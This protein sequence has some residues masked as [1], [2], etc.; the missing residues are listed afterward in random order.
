[1]K[2][3]DI[4]RLLALAAIWG[5]SFMFMRVLA[6]P[7]GPVATAGLRVAIA[8]I[9]LLAYFAVIRFDAQWSRWGRHYLVI[10]VLNSALPFLC[11]AYAALHLPAGYSAILNATTPFFGAMFAALWLGDRLTLRKGAGLAIGAAGVVLVV[12]VG[13]VELDHGFHFAVAACLLAACCYGLSGVY[14]KKRMTGAPPLGVAG[15][16]QLFAG[17]LLL[18][19][20]PLAPP[21]GPITLGIVANLLGLALLCSA[22]ASVLYYRLIANV[23]PTKAMTVTFLIPVFAMMWARLFLGEAVTPTMLG[24]C[25]FVIAGTWLITHQPAPVAAIASTR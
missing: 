23:G 19:A 16:S 15:P 17:V 12:R 21:A 13:R 6:P 18:P 25:A 20:L 7:L 8:G 14:L 2:A 11:F 24:G 4:G 9:V 3:A 1:M 10:G 5:A 22:L